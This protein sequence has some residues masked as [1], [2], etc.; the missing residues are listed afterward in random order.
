METYVAYD[1]GDRLRVVLGDES[2]KKLLINMGFYSGEDSSTWFVNVVGEKDKSAVFEK[3]R[4]AGV[5]F[6]AGKEWSPSE[7]FEYLRDKGFI[8]GGY[9]KI[10]WNSPGKYLVE[11]A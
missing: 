2:A 1:F 10:S 7:I 9:R 6:S 5:C 4:D 8:R 3:L 11:D